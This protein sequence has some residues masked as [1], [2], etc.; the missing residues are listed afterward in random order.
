MARTSP[1]PTRLR[2]PGALAQKESKAAQNLRPS[3]PIKFHISSRTDSGVHALANAAHLDIQRAPGKAAFSEKQLVQGLNYHLKPE[4]ICILS[5][6]RVPST[7]HARFCALSRTYIY[8]L[9]LGCAHHSQI[10]VFERD[11]CWAPAGGFISHSSHSCSFLI[12]PFC[13]LQIQS[14]GNHHKPPGHLCNEGGSKIPAGNPRLQH[15]PLAQ[16]RDPFPVPCQDPAPAGNPT[17][18]WIPVPPQRAQGTGVLGGEVQEQSLPLPT[19]PEDGRGSGC[20]GPGEVVPSGHPGAA[21]GEGCPGFPPSRHGPTLGALPEIR[22][23]QP[24]RSGHSECPSRR[25]AL[26]AELKGLLWLWG[27]GWPSVLNKN[28]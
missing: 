5:A 23:V 12:P 13:L 2:I 6:Q 10:P 24:G 22:G 16:L 4:P 27:G 1:R 8:R 14:L 3:V 25:G 21:G 28:H 9:L 11:L 18:S 20:S 15:L 17:C 26:W 7:F 19:G